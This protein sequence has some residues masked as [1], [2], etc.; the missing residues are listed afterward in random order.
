[1]TDWRIAGVVE[2]VFSGTKIGWA[3]QLHW[4][5]IPRDA[6]AGSCRRVDLGLIR[7]VAALSGRDSVMN[8]SGP[9]SDANDDSAHPQRAVMPHCPQASR[10]CCPCRTRPWPCTRRLITRS[11][12]DLDGGGV[13]CGGQQ[14]SGIKLIDGRCLCTGDGGIG[15]WGT[16]G[17]V[18][19]SCLTLGLGR[20]G[21]PPQTRPPAFGYRPEQRASYCTP[22]LGL[23][24][25]L[26]V[27]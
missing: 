4:L 21:F 19:Q 22:D 1:M 5:W 11:S 16:G 9:D 12:P 23:N 6:L 3:P 14:T 2:A 26:V 7:D 15:E 24:S 8:G 18:S 27:K 13:H 25:V 17:G 10:D 20:L